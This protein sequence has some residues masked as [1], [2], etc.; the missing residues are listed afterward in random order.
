[1]FKDFESISKEN[2][3]QGAPQDDEKF[4]TLLN[5]LAKDLLGQD[6]EG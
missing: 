5:S 6:T 2:N 3:I 1:M 4:S